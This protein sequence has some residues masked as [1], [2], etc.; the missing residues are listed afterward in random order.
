MIFK[1][2]KPFQSSQRLSLYVDGAL[3]AG[4]MACFGI[5]YVQFVQR[6]FPGWSG[7]YLPWL[8]AVISLEVTYTHF[9]NRDKSFGEQLNRRLTEWVVLFFLIKL[10]SML[11]SRQG[12]FLSEVSLWEKDLLLFFSP[13]FLAALL[14]AL[15]VWIASYTFAGDL[16]ALQVEESELYIDGQAMLDRNRID[17]RQRLSEWVMLLGLGVILLA[18]FARFDLVQVFG[19]TFPSR[20]PVYNVVAYFLLGF[21]LLSQAQFGSLQRSW[22]W[23]RIPTAGRLPGRWLAYSLLFFILLALVSLALPT[24]YTIGLLDT[25]RIVVG[26]LMQLFSLLL[27]LLLY[28]FIFLI[29]LLT[30]RTNEDQPPPPPLQLPEID[31]SAPT[32]AGSPLPWLEILRSLAFWL[33]L[34]AIL[35]YFFRSYLLQNK[36]LL[37]S[38]RRVKLLGW[39]SQ[40]WIALRKWL[41]GV[42]LQVGQAIQAGRKRLFPQRRGS[43]AAALRRSINFRRLNPRQRVIFFYLRMIERGGEQGIPR[44]PAQTP[45]QYS[46][47]LRQTLP[48]VGPEL[49]DMTSAF[50]DARYSP[51]Q[52]D[53]EDAAA[54]QSWWKRILQALHRVE[55]P[56]F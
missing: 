27:T 28:P 34:A 21:L 52:V 47:Q 46:Q 1:L 40:A 14:P 29:N 55:K 53:P 9:A 10:L 23:D 2:F 3:I 30:G 41:R 42:N 17:Y 13:A 56:R 18:F 11:F 48:D 44:S 25:L 38:F 12:G 39:L 31:R 43:L 22:L 20:A 49:D 4:M 37:A 45:S 7:G 15:I 26:F 5:S 50:L 32:V 35:I 8:F 36:D 54:V 51:H 19:E 16:A 24:R 33:I 6:I